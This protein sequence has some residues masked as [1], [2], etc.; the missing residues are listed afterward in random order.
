[1]SKVITDAMDYFES[2]DRKAKEEDLK[3]SQIAADYAIYCAMQQMLVHPTSE[4]QQRLEREYS[5]TNAEAELVLQ[6][7]QLEQSY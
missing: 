4:A 2:L 1:M 7:Q 3:R 6:A 5:I